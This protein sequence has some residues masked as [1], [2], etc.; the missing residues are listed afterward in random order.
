M[1]TPTVSE[2]IIAGAVAAEGYVELSLVATAASESY[3]YA[4]GEDLSFLGV[5]TIELVSGE[6]A[7]VLHP[8]HGDSSDVITTPPGTRWKVTT[9]LSSL[10]GPGSPVVRYLNV[11]DETG[12]FEVHE[13]LSSEPVVP[14]LVVEDTMASYTDD[15]VVT[16]EDTYSHGTFPFNGTTTGANPSD[17]W[18]VSTGA[19]HAE[20]GWGWSGLPTDHGDVYFYRMNTRSFEVKNQRIKWEYKSAADGVGGYATSS[21]HAVALWLRYI[22]EFNLYA[23]QFDRPDGRI[24]LKRKVPADGGFTGPGGLT[25]NSGIYYIVPTDSSQPVFGADSPYTTWTGQSLLGLQHN[26]THTTGTIYEFEATIRTLGYDTV[27]VQLFRD[28]ILVG[29]WTD[30]NQGIA[31]NSDLLSAH[32]TAGYFTGVTGYQETWYHP[33]D[34]HGATGFRSDNIQFWWRNFQLWEIGA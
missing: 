22:T 2:T 33:I 21:A 18:E 4:P 16:D 17:I 6:W 27:Q 3:G 20:S 25:A 28:G 7:A 9:R 8:N 10:H 1:S 32:V 15:T 19:L 24:Y 14:V 23:L 26:A 5:Q 34:S 31:A 12:P 29:S 11:P 13:V 30:V